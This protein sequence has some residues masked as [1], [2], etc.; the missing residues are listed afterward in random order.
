MAV[1]ATVVVCLLFGL[2]L[3]ANAPGSVALA[4]AL[5]LTILPILGLGA[6]IARP[7]SARRGGGSG[8][9]IVA[10]WIWTLAVLLTVPAFAPGLRSQAARDGADALF[11]RFLGPLRGPAAGSVGALAGLLGSDGEAA[12]PASPDPLAV[13]PDPAP[14]TD[15]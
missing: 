13:A 8:T 6:G 15:S 9:V 7:G 14:P 3:G 2:G 10:T 4:A 11:A 1:P 12:A 5:A